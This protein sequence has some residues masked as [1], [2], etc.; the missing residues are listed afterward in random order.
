MRERAEITLPDLR[1]RA[2]RRHA[3]AAVV[4]ATV[5]AGLLFWWLRPKTPETRYHTSE[6]QRRDV[7]KVI[8]VTGHL[9]VLDRIEVP[10][11]VSGR[12]VKIA[13]VP[14][15]TVHQ[16]DLLAL[17]DE[18]A[19]ALAVRGAQASLD[20]A[21][22][23]VAKASAA[24]TAASTRAQR[25]QRLAARGLASQADLEAAKS[26]LSEAQA[27]LRAA[28]AQRAGASEQ[29][30]SAELGKQLGRI[31]APDDG[32]VLVAP[33]RLGTIAGPERGP[34]FV[35]GKGLDPLRI[36]A[37]VGEADIGDVK[38]GQHATFTV[39]AYPNR[40][41]SARVER[42]GLQPEQ[43]TSGVTY[44]VA[45]RTANPDHSLMP[46][47]TASVHIQVAEA[48]DVLAV[49]EAALRFTPPGA[50]AAPPRSRVFEKVG[51][52]LVAVPVKAGLSNDAITAVTPVHHGA[53]KAGD[54]VVIGIQV[55]AAEPDSRGLSLGGGGR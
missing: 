22:S 13:A 9:D 12:L 1:R 19:A 49:P 47:M 15:Q 25:V 21:A 33:E 11:P 37:P 48:H 30:A 31:V 2:R 5:I 29:V 26:A 34:L 40:T 27:T 10:A 38:V 14:G 18:R 41:M 52:R 8:D 32:V 45:L 42:V 43:E 23:E 16:G 54:H 28:R 20:A 4:V 46:G 7:T 50:P 36:N 39:P 17:L 55:P 24:V 44:P 35:L 51:S 53:L 3:I 6:V